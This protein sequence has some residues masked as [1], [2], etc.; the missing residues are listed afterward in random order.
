MPVENSGAGFDSRG[1]GMGGIY[2]FIQENAK[3]YKPSAE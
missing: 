2:G 1:A 3:Y